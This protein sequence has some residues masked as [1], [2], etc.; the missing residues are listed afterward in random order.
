MLFPT[1]FLLA[2]AAS[3][4]PASTSILEVDLDADG[5]ADLVVLDDR[6]LRVLVNLG[7]SGYEDRTSILG[8]SELGGMVQVVPVDPNADGVPDLVTLTADGH[9]ALYLNVADQGFQRATG[10]ASALQD[11]I[12][13]EPLSSAAGGADEVLLRTR[14]GS[15][16]LNYAG[17]SGAYVFDFE[18]GSM[19]PVGSDVGLSAS[20][21]LPRLADSA[22][23]IGNATCLSASSQPVDGAFYPLGPNWF[24]DALTGFVGVG[25]ITPS[26]RLDVEG[27]LRTDVLEFPDGSSQD[28]A[29]PVGPQGPQGPQGPE[30]EAGPVGPS[31]GSGP[32]G[33]QGPTGPQGAQGPE[34]PTGPDGPIGPQ[35]SQGPTGPVGNEGPEGNG[36]G[37]THTICVGPGAFTAVGNGSG[38]AVL[39]TGDGGGG[40]FLNANAKA[41]LIAPINVPQGARFK[42]LT[43]YLYDAQNGKDLVV[44]LST[45]LLD[46]EYRGHTNHR[47]SSGNGG[48]SSFTFSAQNL[49]ANDEHK[50]FYIRTFPVRPETLYDELGWEANGDLAILGAIVEYELP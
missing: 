25:T 42:Q 48:Y 29:L 39:R 4:S 7:T 20:A 5:D 18:T 30:G 3:D 8:L 14:R 6:H 23:P 27:R 17:G 35:G 40:A 31:G 15:R 22:Y 2:S 43:Y 28:T 10:E 37:G 21:C 9:V 11:V 32:E 50:A 47:W 1:L 46:Q 19:T 26:Q 36:Y 34:G 49:F 45:E 41:H 24:V 13:L 33:P 12:A 38:V 44:G 16:V